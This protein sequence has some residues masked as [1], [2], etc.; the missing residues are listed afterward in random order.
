MRCA[1]PCD[2]LSHAVPHSQVALVSHKQRLERVAF[3]FFVCRLFGVLM[4][5]RCF[6][7]FAMLFSTVSGPERVMRSLKFVTPL[8]KKLNYGY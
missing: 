3:R 1:A 4:F 2:G 7:C 5:S 6:V 8:L